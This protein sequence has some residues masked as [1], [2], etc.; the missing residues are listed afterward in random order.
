MMAVH[1]ATLGDARQEWVDW[2]ISDPQYAHDAEQ[3]GRRWDSLHADK[4]DAPMVQFGTLRHFLAEAKA[5]DVLPP[6]QEAAAADF[7]GADDP[8][9]DLSEVGRGARPIKLN[10]VSADNIDLVF[11][12]VNIHGKV[13]IVYLG[14]KSSLDKSVR[15]PEIWL[16][17]DFQ[18]AL[19]NKYVNVE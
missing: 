13:R 1:H 5:L 17:D 11:K 18:R 2:C 19:R 3:I 10:E 9:F 7:E 14:G 12:L 8:D 16:E 15:V 4:S 6:D